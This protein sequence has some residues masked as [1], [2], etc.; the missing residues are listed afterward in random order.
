MGHVA[1]QGELSDRTIR[2]AMVYGSVMASFCVEK[3][4]VERLKTLTREEINGR[5]RAFKR[6]CHFEE[7]EA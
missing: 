5:F 4:S 6:M 1:Q 3:F 2:R 7:L